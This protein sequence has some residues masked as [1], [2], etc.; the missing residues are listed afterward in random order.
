MKVIRLS[1][2]EF[3]R[4]F[5]VH[6]LPSGSLRIRHTGFLANGI[7]RDRIEKIRHLLN[8]TPNPDQAPDTDKT[9]DPDDTHAQQTCPKCGSAMTVIET[10]N[11]GQLP[12]SRAPPWESAA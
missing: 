1:T 9:D 2:D 7:R 12:K 4:G 8:V 11:R 5:L 3:I 6:V 10:F